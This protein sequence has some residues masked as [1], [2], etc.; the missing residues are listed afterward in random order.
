MHS[1]GPQFDDP[2]E[3]VQ[4]VKSKLL[5]D[6]GLGQ[7]TPERVTI[8]VLQQMIRERPEKISR[9]LRRWLHPNE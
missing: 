4:K 3:E 7:K 2:D 5:L 9:A 8:E 6:F 1:T